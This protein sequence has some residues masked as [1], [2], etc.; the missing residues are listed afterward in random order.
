MRHAEHDLVP[1]PSSAA[2][3]SSD[4][5]HRDER[6]GAFEAEALLARGTWCGGSARTPRPRSA[7]RGSALLVVVERRSACAPSTCS[8]IQSFCSGSW[9]CMYSTPIVR[10]VRVAQDAEDV[11]QQLSCDRARRAEAAGR[12]L[13]VEVPDREAP[14]V[15]VE[16]GVRVRLL[17]RPSGSRF[18]MRWPRTRYMLMSCWTLTT[19]SNAVSASSSGLTS[20]A[21]ARRLVRDAEAAGRSRRRSRRRRAAGRASAARNS[22]LSAPWMMRWS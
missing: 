21:P 14:V 18:A 7:A 5:E 8:W 16:L 19:F 9:M 6:L 1:C 15:E 4:V 2:A 10:G 17:A 11:A 13:A 3:S 20:R 12:E 22:P